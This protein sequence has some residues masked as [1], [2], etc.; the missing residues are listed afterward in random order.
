LCNACFSRR[1]L[2][3]GAALLPFATPALAAKP[4]TKGLIEPHMR[5]TGAGADG[6]RV[7]LTFDAC[8]GH[9]DR[10]VLDMLL[11]EKIPA[12]IFA[13]GK[14]LRGNAAVFKELL[15]H[16]ELFEIGDHGAHHCAAIDRTEMIWGVRAAGSGQGVDA[17]VSEGA[18]LLEAAGAPRPNW[19]RGATALYTRSAMQLIA[20]LGYRIAGF[21]IN[22]DQGASLS[23]EGTARRYHGA[24][25]GDVLISHINQ[26][27]RPAGAGVVRG[28]LAL[29]ARG[30]QFVKLSDPSLTIAQFG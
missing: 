23:A 29:K 5:I 20:G 15:A 13:S 27:T 3:Q 17:E 2:L 26:P 1:M 28:V 4:D 18:R 14:W 25:D 21:S 8:D 24:S 12:T 6:P 19:F 30:V 9:T 10:R 16:P 22:A 11:A 7:A